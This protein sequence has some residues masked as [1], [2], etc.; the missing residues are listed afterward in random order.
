MTLCIKATN[1]IKNV[2]MWVY[3]IKE[4]HLITGENKRYFLGKNPVSYTEM[5][6]LIHTADLQDI[7]YADLSKR[8]GSLG[9]KYAKIHVDYIKE[10]TI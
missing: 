8:V 4:Y 6:G 2:F 9:G 10:V 1:T 7:V 3:P 5:S